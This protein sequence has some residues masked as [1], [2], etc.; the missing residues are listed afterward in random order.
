M[1]EGIRVIQEQMRFASIE[2]M[3]SVLAEFRDFYNH[4]RPHQALKGQTPAMVWNEQVRVRL[5]HQRGGKLTSHGARANQRR[6]AGAP[7]GA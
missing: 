3:Q 1:R 7:P 6:S 2:T 4:G 5:D